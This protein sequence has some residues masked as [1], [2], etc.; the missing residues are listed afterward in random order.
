MSDFIAIVSASLI[1]IITCTATCALLLPSESTHRAWVARIASA[2][3]ARATRAEARAQARAARARAAERATWR[4][5]FR[6]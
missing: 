6:G 1:A 2:R 5:F 4:R 3:A